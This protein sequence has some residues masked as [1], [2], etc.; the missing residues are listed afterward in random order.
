MED[1]RTGEQ[2]LCRM[3]EFSQKLHGYITADCVT[4]LAAERA[5]MSEWFE[6]LSQD[7]DTALNEL[8]D[9]LMASSKYRDCV[10]EVQ[11]WLTKAERD[12]AEFV[13]RA[14]LHQNPAI[15]LDQ[16]R[17]SQVDLEGNQ[18]KLDVLDRLGKCC[19]LA[20]AEQV[21]D[22]FCERYKHLTNDLKVC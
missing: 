1:R 21:Y 12:M 7:I 9:H 11:T 20:E 4:Q 19:G 14:Q 15:H 22:S 17:V 13:S 16:L 10:D 8:T 18:E 6:S 5:R 2:L 3:A